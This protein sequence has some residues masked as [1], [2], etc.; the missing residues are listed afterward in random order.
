MDVLWAAFAS[1]LLGFIFWQDFDPRMAVFFAVGTALAETFVLIRRQSSIACKKCGFD[2]VLYRKSP[3]LA[4]ARVKDFYR[5]K[6]E[7]PMSVFSPPA[8]L[9]VIVKKVDRK[10]VSL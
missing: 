1:V 9:P 8:K 4:A 5:Q 2:P 6:A 7:D 10:S 3:A